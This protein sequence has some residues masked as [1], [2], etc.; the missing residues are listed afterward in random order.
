MIIVISDVNIY[1]LFFKISGVGLCENKEA[2]IDFLNDIKLLNVY[3]K[4]VCF[5]PVQFSKPHYH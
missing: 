3:N 1:C 2:V 5:Q 4:N